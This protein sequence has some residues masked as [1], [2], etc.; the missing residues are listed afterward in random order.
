MS[1]A[2]VWQAFRGPRLDPS[3]RGRSVLITGGSRGLGLE[4]ARRF[5]AEGARVALVAR[6]VDELD[7]AVGDLVEA[8]VPVIAIAAD[9][10]DPEDVERVVSEVIAV[11]GSIDVL[12]NNAG[13]IQVG[14]VEHMSEDDYR[15]SLEVHF[16]GPLHMIRACFPHMLRQ[17]GGRIVNVSSIGGLVA[18]PHLGPYSAGKHALVGLSEGLAIELARHGIAVTTVCPGLLC[19]GSAVNA[20]VKG[21]HGPE[22]GWFTA[23]STHPL[24]AMDSAVAAKQVVEATRHGRARRVLGI[25][26]RLLDLFATIL[27]TLYVAVARV[28]VRWLPGPAGTRGDEGRRG[29]DVSPALAES[30]RG[31]RAALQNN[32]V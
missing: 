18:V 26:A 13:V 5:G 20:E 28:V 25:Q 17:G 14:P 31:F 16:W 12:V 27:P 1:L 24:L 29:G 9:V 2:E 11:F 30:A 32:E 15:S 21:Q 7:R 19:T 3:F 6:D 23:A 8:G 10:A 22:Y 4:L